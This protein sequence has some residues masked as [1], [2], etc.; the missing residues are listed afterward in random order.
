MKSLRMASTLAVL[1]SLHAI[2]TASPLLTGASQ[3]PKL[4]ERAKALDSSD[5]LVMLLLVH[6][7]Y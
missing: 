6:H 5:A 7:A 3:L 1:A 2:V 4:V